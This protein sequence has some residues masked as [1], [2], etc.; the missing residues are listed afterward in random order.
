MGRTND[1]V[2]DLTGERLKESI[3]PVVVRIQVGV[4]PGALVDPPRGALKALSPF[5]ERMLFH[6]NGAARPGLLEV[7]AQAFA[8]CFTVDLAT[9]E[10]AFDGEPPVGDPTA[11]LRTTVAALQAENRAL[12]EKARQESARADAIKAATEAPAT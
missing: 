8:E 7:G 11:Q 5:L 3:F 4:V 10:P 1:Y 9:L 12:A 6:P 2:C